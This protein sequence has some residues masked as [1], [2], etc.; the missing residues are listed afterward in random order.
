MH[1]SRTAIQIG[2]AGAEKAAPYARAIDATKSLLF[3]LICYLLGISL[4]ISAAIILV[5]S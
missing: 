3:A 2:V 4:L 5:S 1:S